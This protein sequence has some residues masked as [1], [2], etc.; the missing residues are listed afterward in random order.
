[1]CAFWA[2]GFFGLGLGEVEVH[3]SEQ[4][5]DAKSIA[6]STVLRSRGTSKLVMMTCVRTE[7]LGLDESACRSSAVVDLL[8]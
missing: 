6:A 2:A 7:E 5:S 4:L 1:M 8:S 3:V